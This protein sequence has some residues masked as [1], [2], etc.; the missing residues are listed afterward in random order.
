[1]TLDHSPPRVVQVALNTSDMAGSL[2]LYAE[3]LGFANGGAS[4][5]WGAMMGIAGLDADARTLMWWLVGR[6]EYMQLELYAISRPQQQPLPADWRPSDHGWVRFGVA[7]ADFDRTLTVLAES[8]IDT[9]SEPIT[10]DGLRRAAFRDPY[11]GIVVEVLEDGD[12]LPGGM[13]EHHFDLGPAI[14]YVTSS[15]A[16]LDSARAFYERALGLAPEALELL[17][18]PGDEAL[19][20]LDGASREG[21]VVRAGGGV[22]LEVV[23]YSQPAGRPKPDSYRLCDQGLAHVCL[24][25]TDRA[26][27]MELIERI[28]SEGLE[29][30]MLAGDEEAVATYFTAPGREFERLLGAPERLHARFGFV[31]AQPFIPQEYGRQHA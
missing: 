3:A 1:M 8:G 14:A 11:A 24:G 18:E 25:S 16:D 10:R 23:S 4:A 17:H 21:F 28:R 9:L 26:S 5:L 30:T 22:L 12:A 7:V 13:R 2:R 31:P 27:A 19:W 6:Q 29:S 15:V 20:G